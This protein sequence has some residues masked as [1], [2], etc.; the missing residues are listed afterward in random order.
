MH[1]VQGGQTI[2]CASI[3]NWGQG[4]LMFAAVLGS[5]YVGG[6]VVLGSK[7]GAGQAGLKGHPHFKKWVELH[8]MVQ[9]GVA[10]ARGGK[11]RQPRGCGPAE[12]IGKEAPLLTT[13]TEH[14]G[15]RRSEKSKTNGK[16]KSS[17]KSKSTS[18]APIQP[19]SEGDADR[20]RTVTPAVGAVAAPAAPS[21]SKKTA[22][23]DGGR[24][25]HVPG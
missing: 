15:R 19:Q 4:F 16:S 18:S 14:D 13:S 5:A 1:C 11:N 8:A 22:A 20:Q 24:W 12:Q 25:V 3:S 10:F 17:S 2:Y 9:D 23:G 21:A 6:G 7:Q